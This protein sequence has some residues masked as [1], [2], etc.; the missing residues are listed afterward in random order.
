MGSKLSREDRNN[1]NGFGGQI[2]LKRK[3][4][5]SLMI[6]KPLR[7]CSAPSETLIEAFELPNSWVQKNRIGIWADLQPQ[8][9]NP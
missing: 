9:E 6:Q 8:N 5:M 1:R 3:A 2:L 4:D 7:T